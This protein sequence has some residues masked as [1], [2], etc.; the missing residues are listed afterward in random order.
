MDHDKYIGRLLDNRYEILE[1][2]GI[3]GMAIVYKARC[4]RLNRLVAIKILKDEFSKD[5]DF[6]RRFHAEGQAVAMVSHPNIVSVYDVS[7]TNEAD[8][9]VME[10][11]DG[12]S[13]KQYMEKKGV[14]NWKETLH[15]GIQICKALEHAHSRGIVHRDI[16]P[17]N[18]MVLKNGSVKVADFGIARVMSKGNTLTKEALGS[19]HYIS[20]EQAK[21]G[22]VDDRSDIYSLGTVMYEMMTG[23]PPYDG[24]S[25][26]A[27]AIQHING[28]AKMPSTINPAIPGG[29]EQIIM[30]AMAHEPADRYNTATAMLYD[31]DEFRKAPAILFDYNIPP[32]DAVTRLQPGVRPTTAQRV[33]GST[34]RGKSGEFSSA[35]QRSEARRAQRSAEVNRSSSQSARSRSKKEAEEDRG[36]V[37]V[38][39]VI[40]CSV[41]A[42]IAII[43]FLI[44]LF[45]SGNPPEPNLVAVP[46]LVGKSYDTLQI[47]GDFVLKTPNYQ[48]SDMYEKGKI[49]Y[50]EPEPG[51]QVEKG[52]EIYIWISLGPEPQ[53]KTMEDLVNQERMTAENY[54]NGQKVSFLCKEEYSEDVREGYVIRT[55]PEAGTPLEEGQTVMLYISLGPK[56]KKRDM[57]NVVGQ[58][59]ETAKVILDKQEL[60]LN[61]KEIE[62][63]SSEVEEGYVIR[64]LPATGEPLKTGD[65]VV[66]YVSKG[67]EKGKMPD[68]R[69][70]DIDTAIKMLK[71]AGFDNIDYSDTVES[72]QEVDTVVEQSV[73]PGEEIPITTTIQLT[74]SSGPKAEEKTKMVHFGL[75]EDMLEAYSVK[76]VR[77]DTEEVVFEAILPSEQ[78]EIELELKGSGKVIYK[79]TMCETNIYTQEVDFDAP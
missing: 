30:K 16:K 62:E 71:A 70:E 68:V 54:L 3:G 8:Y 37:A 27:V 50:Q 29:L 75:M 32:T 73:E 44:A 52:T 31:M 15:F 63:V 14:L 56:T 22:R 61:V 72:D 60:D 41:V 24:E 40:A 2:I 67:P 46:T 34:Q 77:V 18:V 45:G 21:G 48:H 59:L 25:P 39:A 78:S 36:R 1:V 57:P 42:I 10:L 9:I 47:G 69:G 11:I 64:T 5:E 76:I 12:I 51:K 58:S 19:V 49:A 7:S 66:I 53:V 35:V 43:V 23:R 28:G 33:A 55:E 13:L 4:H 20:P 65:T 74:L 6:R 79:V 26:V 17:H 38:I